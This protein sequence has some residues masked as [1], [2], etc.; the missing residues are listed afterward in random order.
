MSI[1]P[2]ERT[3]ASATYGLV[4]FIGGGAPYVA[5]KLVEHVNAKLPFL[6]GARPG[7]RQHA[8]DPHDLRADRDVTVLPREPSTATTGDQIRKVVRR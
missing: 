2:V 4:R 5:G 8:A 7:R 6:I 3:V 1:A